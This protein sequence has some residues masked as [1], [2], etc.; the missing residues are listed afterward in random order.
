MAWNHTG[1]KGPDCVAHEWF[2]SVFNVKWEDLSRGVI[3]S[4]KFTVLKYH[5][6]SSVVS[7]R[8]KGWSVLWIP[9]QERGN[10]GGLD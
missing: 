1:R 5:I 2:Y 7:K 6:G 8:R 4:F 9:A 3:Y 10:G